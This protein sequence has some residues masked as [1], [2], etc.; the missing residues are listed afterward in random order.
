M[1]F[2]FHFRSAGPPPVSRNVKSMQ[3]AQDTANRSRIHLSLDFVV[4]EASLRRAMSGLSGAID[5]KVGF[6]AFIGSTF[7]GMP[8]PDTTY[9]PLLAIF[10]LPAGRRYRTFDQYELEAGITALVYPVYRSEKTALRA[11][12]LNRAIP[13]FH[14]GL[15]KCRGVD[16]PRSFYVLHDYTFNELVF[17]LNQIAGAKA[18]SRLRLAEDS[19]VVVSLRSGVAQL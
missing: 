13:A 18:G 14:S 8:R 3:L 4:S 10:Y 12:L 1:W 5:L 17:G 7:P 19:R 11:A 9:Y 16:K 15:E 2:Y 6:A